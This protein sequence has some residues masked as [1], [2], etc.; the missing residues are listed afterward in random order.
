MRSTLGIVVAVNRDR[1][2][3]V[4]RVENERHAVVGH[5][6]HGLVEL[7][8]VLTGDFCA[9]G[10][11]VLRNLTTGEN[12]LVRTLVADSSFDEASLLAL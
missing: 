10:A 11:A 12:L 3:S 9:A 6:D 7:G 1:H 5:E 4:V 8:D 2:V